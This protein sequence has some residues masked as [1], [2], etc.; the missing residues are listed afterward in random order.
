MIVL[1]KRPIGESKRN[2]N[3]ADKSKHESE[4]EDLTAAAVRL[5]CH[6][7]IIVFCKVK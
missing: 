7:M 1:L 3:R 6:W 4:S 2:G 5:L